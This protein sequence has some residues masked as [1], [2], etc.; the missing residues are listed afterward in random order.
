[1]IRH[2]IEEAFAL[3]SLTLFLGTVLIVSAILRGAI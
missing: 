3:V 2:F 1:M